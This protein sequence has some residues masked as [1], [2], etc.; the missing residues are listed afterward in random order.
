MLQEIFRLMRLDDTI[1]YELQ[2]RYHICPVL[3]NDIVEDE[4]TVDEKFLDTLDRI[5][6]HNES[7]K[8]ELALQWKSGQSGGGGG[9]GRAHLPR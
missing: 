8:T 4:P 3:I 5:L 7:A 1:P 6:E 9:V 2:T